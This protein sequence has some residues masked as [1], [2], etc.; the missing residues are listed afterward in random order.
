MKYYY[1]LRHTLFVSLMVI[2]VFSGCAGTEPSR[3]YRL[4]TLQDAH[5]SQ[6]T[7]K[8]D[9][10]VSIGIGPINIPDSHKRPQIVTLTSTN[11]MDLGEFDRWAG[12]LEDNMATVIAENLS[13]LLSTDNIHVYP[14]SRAVTTDYQV[15]VD[16]IRFDGMLGENA[17]L[18][19]RRTVFGEDGQKML[20]KKR[21]QYIEPAEGDDYGALVAAMSR[22]L[23][24][25]SRDTAEAIRTASKNGVH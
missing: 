10:D 9:Q 1:F 8:A 6:D 2:S 17:V 7:M 13:M 23:A 3:F 11:E 18:I 21:V 20:M 14:W 5:M 12:A 16:I 15:I 22:A 24:N 19:A 4:S 25:F